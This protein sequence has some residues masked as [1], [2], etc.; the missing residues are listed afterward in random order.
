M[1]EQW[2]EAKTLIKGNV[3]I[4]INRSLHANGN[5]FHS[6][7][8]SHLKPDAQLNQY[9]RPPDLDN[10]K[11]LIDEAKAWIQSDVDELRK[12]LPT[13]HAQ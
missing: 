10:L 7:R 11:L 9:L 2:L 3:A 12:A 5:V 1:P 8:V 6:V 4:L 13:C